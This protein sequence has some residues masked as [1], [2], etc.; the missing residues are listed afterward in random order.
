M[1]GSSLEWVNYVILVQYIFY[2]IIE[3]D[4]AI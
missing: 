2:L 4:P 3:V 1:G